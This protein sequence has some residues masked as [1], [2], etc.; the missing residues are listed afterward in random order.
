MLPVL[1]PFQLTDNGVHL[2]IIKTFMFHLIFSIGFTPYKAI[3]P[4]LGMESKIKRKTIRKQK[5]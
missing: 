2:A 3:Q 4:L 5:F 1:Q